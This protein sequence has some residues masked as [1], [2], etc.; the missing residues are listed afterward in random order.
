M[1]MA[2]DASSRSK[3]R[4][5]KSVRFKINIAIACVFFIVA[6]LVINHS[7]VNERSKNLQLAVTQVKGM[8]AFYFDSLNTLMLADVME[9]REVLREKMLEQ[10]GVV[11]VRVNR[12]EAINA[13]FGPG[14][15]S[16]KAVDELDRRGLAGESV[17][18]VSEVD[19]HR[20]VTVVEPY[21]LTEDTRGT[22]CLECHRKV[23]SGTVGG[24][25]RVTYSLAEADEL[26]AAGFWKQV[27]IMAGLFLVGL[28][29]LSLW[30]NRVVIAP[31]NTMV[32]RF[33]DIAT[34][35]GDLTRTLDEKSGDELAELAHWFNHFVDKLRHMVVDISGYT[36]E[37]THAAESMGGIAQQTSGAARQQQDETSQVA[38]AMNQMTAAVQDISRNAT[39][40]A[41]A[42]R[43][44]NDE[45]TQ[46]REVMHQTSSAIGAL[47]N[48][49]EQAGGV[50]QQLAKQSDDI[51]VVLDVIRGIA[52]QTNLLALNAA[53]EAARAGEQGRGFAVVAD[54]VRTLAERTQKS[55]EEIR[56][57]IAGLQDG[58]G[59]AVAVM[60][61]GQE[62]ATLS[63]SQASA[64]ETSL[65]AVTD[66][67]GN[68]TD[69]CTQIA[70][71]AE[72]QDKVSCEVNTNVGN[73]SQLASRTASDA[74]SV[75]AANQQLTEMANKLQELLQQ[76]RV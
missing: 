40:A 2:K 32:D 27:G 69:M 4:P 33:R 15:P 8:N 51:S 30:M 72:E 6:L 24:A 14:L 13:K 62:Q 47:A 39:L 50:I 25:I 71:A 11:E 7:Y 34:G 9:E 61:R 66:L 12:S 18:E 65:N 70:A 52:E 3:I 26:V 56:S 53:I 60:S 46:G 68:I 22:N 36:G 1:T 45:A 31:V 21:L 29:A 74:G 5:T 58:A 16:E 63:V 23:E 54:E 76:F 35:D 10:P 37:L 19:G 49:V 48:E 17:L 44:A 64:A 20:T 28:L 59:N 75:A 55:T 41:D 43:D 57:M 67:I 42:A 38:T 73:I